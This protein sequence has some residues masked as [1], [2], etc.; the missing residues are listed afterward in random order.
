MTPKNAVAPEIDEGP[1]SYIV[2]YTAIDY[3][4]NQV[5][6]VANS[7]YDPDT[8]QLDGTTITATFKYNPT[9]EITDIDESMFDNILLILC[10]L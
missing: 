1:M 8:C 6:T 9:S 5:M 2:A 7:S 4:S 10:S 3:N